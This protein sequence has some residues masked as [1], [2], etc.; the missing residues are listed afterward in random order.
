MPF[1]YE[2]K[3]N[4]V[5]FIM[6]IP[7]IVC[8]ALFYYLPMFGVILAFKNY[9][10]SK[11][12]F[13]SEWSGFNNFEFLFKTDAAYLIT[14][15]TILYNLAFI[16]LGLI[17]SVFIAIV[18]NE[19]RSKL[20]ARVYQTIFIMPHF[21]SWVVVSFISYSFLSVDKGFFNSVLASVGQ[22]PIAWYSEIKYWP[23]ILIF[24]HIWKSV[25][26]TCVIYLAAIIGISNDYYEAAMLDGAS[27]WKQIKCITIPFLKPMMIMLTILE[28]GRIFY[29]DFGLFYQVPRDSGQLYDATQVIDTYVIKAQNCRIDDIRR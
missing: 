19:L 9:N 12:I 8:L 6:T 28:I 25:G 22:D 26:F 29:A 15:N 5:L 27:K 21:L 17:I 14:R 3:K 1:L 23:P 4:R 11:G 7:A 13:G 2:L 16:V 24:A 10:F 20:F 18:L